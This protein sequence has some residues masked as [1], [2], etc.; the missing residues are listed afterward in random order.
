[1]KKI[2][3]CSLLALFFGFGQ[4]VNASGK[5]GCASGHHSG[6][7]GG[8]HGSYHGGY[9]G[10]HHNHAYHSSSG[11]SQSVYLVKTETTTRDE[12]FPNCTKH[13]MKTQVTTNH[14]SDGSK[15]T[16]YSSTI[17]NSDGSVIASDCNKVNHITYNNNHYFIICKFSS[18][19]GCSIIDTNGKAVTEKTYSR[20]EE[21][22]ENRFFV[23]YDKKYGIIDLKE[24]EIVPV[25]YQRFFKINN[26]TFITKLNGYY[27]ILN[28]ENKVLVKNECEKIRPMHKTVLIKKCGKYGLCNLKGEVLYKAK[29]DKI[30]HL[31]EYILIKKSKKY[32]ILD[33]EGKMVSDAKYKKV[34]LRR[35][36]L[37]GY[38]G[39]KWSEV[40]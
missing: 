37:Y 2:V 9:H 36:T 14:Y 12:K 22:K 19:G 27:G 38:D 39:K 15:R 26:E 28:I 17:Y 35:N 5:C 31:G 1:M 21:L 20:I 18:K 13:Y 8:Y 33:S 3:I 34:R 7:H 4:C 11:S 23:K 16:L 29:Y 30:R 10:H 25:K 40:K 32:Q 6:H 24:N